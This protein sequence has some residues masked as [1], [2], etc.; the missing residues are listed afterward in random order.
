MNTT[1]QSLKPLLLT[2]LWDILYTLDGQRNF[3]HAHGLSYMDIA[4]EIGA[5]TWFL[6]EIKEEK[7]DP[8]AA[9]KRI[10]QEYEHWQ[11]THHFAQMWAQ[12]VP[13]ILRD[14]VA[15]WQKM[16]SL[17]DVEVQIFLFTILLHTQPEMNRYADLL[18][19]LNEQK[20]YHVLSVLLRLPENAVAEALHPRAKLHNI[21]IVNIDRSDDYYL[22]QKVELLSRR[23]AET[24]MNERLSPIEILKQHIQLAPPTALGIQDFKHLGVLVQ[25]AQMYL[26]QV[27]ERQQKG[28][29]IL[30]HGLAGTG[31]TEF[32]RVLAQSLNMELFEIAWADENDEPA[33]R[34]DRM[35]ALRMAQNILAGQRTL[36]MFDEVE[37]LFDREQHEF[38]L[39]KAWLNRLLENNAVPTIWV[40]NQVDLIDPSAVRR[41]DMVLEMS[42]PPIAARANMIRAYTSEFYSEQQ[43][44]SLAEHD[45]L[46]PAV[47]KQAH[48]ITQYTSDW[49]KAQRGELFKTLLRNT[50]RAQGNHKPLSSQTKLPESYNVDWINCK[51]DLR[52]IAQGVA[53]AGR[54]TLCFYGAAGT[55]KSAYAAWLAQQADRPLIYKRA[56]DLLDKYVGETEQRIAAAFAEAQT[57]QAVLVFDEVDSFLQDRRGSRQSWEITQ[58]NEMLTQMEAY[59]GIFIAST[60]LMSNLD[61]AALR[62]FDFKLEF[63]YLRGEQAWAM[64]V[65][66]CEQFALWREDTG[67]LKTELLRLK[68]VAAGDFAV[69]AKQAR[70]TPFE[71]AAAMLNALKLECNLKDGAKNA[72]GFF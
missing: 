37:D 65:F 4:K 59:D 47:L 13:T 64:F 30:I 52:A 15:D 23:F 60:N 31:K 41:F 48:K 27:F 1:H 42:I 66:Y 6:A 33:N 70:I 14:N 5:D 7:F 57:E 36:L 25:A 11:Q 68:N 43:I 45:A 32:A 17:N 38:S 63:G 51:Q 50:L 19:S 55:G 58:V 24:M 9:R 2:W 69:L 35:N 61:Q 40:C 39:N 22:R 20:V 26:Q 12:A 53:K 72:M 49:D 8:I 21:G 62:R 54:G 67:S 29:N 56:S 10:Q 16:F 71:S 18:E 3:V 34:H 44:R 28:C 46:V